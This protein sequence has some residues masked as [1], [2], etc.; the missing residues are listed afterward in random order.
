MVM[1][2]G[3][4]ILIIEDD[5]KLRMALFD[6]L[7]F[8]QYVVKSVSNGEK[9]NDIIK[10]SLP[11]IIII[12]LNLPGEDGLSISK[13]IRAALPSVGIIML[14]G[15]DR[16]HDRAVGYAAGAD[17]YLTKPS[18]TSELLQVIVNLSK[19]L[20]FRQKH[21]SWLLDTEK[22]QLQLPRGKLILLTGL[23]TLL[24]MELV[25]HGKFI[26]HAE[27][28]FYLSGQNEGSEFNKSRIEVLLSRLR[29]KVSPHV[30]PNLFVKAVRGRGYQ[31]IQPVSLLNLVSSSQS[32]FAKI[33]LQ[34]DQI[35]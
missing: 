21:E 7:V 2:Q 25:L 20:S 14:T 30:D 12:D 35:Q 17:I 28:I 33:P 9:V 4:S 3:I 32:A 18:S 22:R 34:S 24:V 6:F 29:K 10:L 16:R 19:R 13:R 5:D 26:S 23:E 27:L 8:H 11:D 31:L 15:R 1:K